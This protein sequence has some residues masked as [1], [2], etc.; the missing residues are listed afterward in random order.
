MAYDV[1]F[2][3]SQPASNNISRKLG[4]TV[5]YKCTVPVPTKEGVLSTG[6][7]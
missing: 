5:A 6:R 4:T 3:T 2:V 7:K 1:F